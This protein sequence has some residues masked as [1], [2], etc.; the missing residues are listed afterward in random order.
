MLPGGWSTEAAAAP[1]SAMGQI[2]RS[3]LEGHPAGLS[4]GGFPYCPTGR[5][6][7]CL[8]DGRSKS[9]RP[10]S[11]RKGTLCRL[12]HDQRTFTKERRLPVRA[13][14]KAARCPVA[15]SGSFGP[16]EGKAN[17]RSFLP[18]TFLERAR[19]IVPVRPEGERWRRSVEGARRRNNGD[20]RGQRGESERCARQTGMRPAHNGGG[21]STLY[22]RY[23]GPRSKVAT[24]NAAVGPRRVSAVGTT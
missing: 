19:T 1:P 8:P 2:F 6:F 11:N 24:V 12:P 3:Q 10:L 4:L 13:A 18:S 21:S 23:N 15:S 9:S 5:P 7:A 16:G 22:S 20:V 14:N 17:F